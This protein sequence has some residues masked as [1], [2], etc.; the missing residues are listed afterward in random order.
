MERLTVQIYEIQDSFEAER[1]IEAG[2]D[3][4]GSVLLSEEGWKVSAIRDAIRLVED[5]SISSSL[6]PLF[7]RPEAI[8]RAIDWYRPDIIHFCE[9]LS[10]SGGIPP[11]VNNLVH[12]QEDLKKRYPEIKVMRS[13]PIAM[14][15]QAD[16][17]P[18][19]ELAKMFEHVS[20]VFLTDTLLFETT[21]CDKE[22]PVDGFVGITGVTCDWTMAKNLVDQSSIPV[23]LAGGLS[24]DNVYEAAI[25]INPAGVD[26]CTQ[27]NAVGENGKPIRFNKDLAKVRQFVEEARRAEK[28]LKSE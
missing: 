12:V 1:M 6:I 28:I 26:S 20:D 2:V 10:M 19:L 13:I 16:M 23:I 25:R 14:Q 17:V 22:Q 27:T 11:S 15:G 8:F 7:S 18:T 9:S 3:R 24:P 4:I 5:N 21:G